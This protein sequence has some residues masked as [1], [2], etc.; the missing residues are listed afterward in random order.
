MASRL[1][2]NWRKYAAPAKRWRTCDLK[3]HEH[4]A[5]TSGAASHPKEKLLS[6]PIDFGAIKNVLFQIDHYREL[7]I[8]Y[9]YHLLSTS[10]IN[11]K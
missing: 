9:S 2:Y 11:I 3:H 8:D 6:K 7:D 4:S 1:A 5:T 10:G